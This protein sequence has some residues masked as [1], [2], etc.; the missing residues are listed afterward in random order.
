M[1][2]KERDLNPGYAEFQAYIHEY[3]NLFLFY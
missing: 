1:S 3:I 2:Q